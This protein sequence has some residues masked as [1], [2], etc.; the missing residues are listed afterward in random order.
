[1]VPPD[2]KHLL[3]VLDHPLIRVAILGV[4]ALA[5]FHC[6]HRFSYILRDGLRLKHHQQI[7]TITCYTGAI[8]GSLIA[9]YILLRT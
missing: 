1:V 5:L 4:C 3:A 8:T 9:S 6:A 2:R 7:T